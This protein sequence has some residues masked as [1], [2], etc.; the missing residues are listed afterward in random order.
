MIKQGQ[1]L[2]A[3]KDIIS[4]IDNKNLGEQKIFW[5]QKIDKNQ[6]LIIFDRIFR[7]DPYERKFRIT[8]ERNFKALCKGL[9][10]Q[11]STNL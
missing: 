5:Y 2:L 3:S 1:L 6:Y 11:E 8:T 4:P 10:L 7:K 9:K